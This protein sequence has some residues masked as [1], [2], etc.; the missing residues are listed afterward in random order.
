MPVGF[1]ET[2][3]REVWEWDIRGV[4]KKDREVV[5]RGEMVKDCPVKI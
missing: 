1:M 4:R 3:S 5:T 2:P